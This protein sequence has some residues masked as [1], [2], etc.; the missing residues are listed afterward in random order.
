MRREGRVRLICASLP[1]KVMEKWKRRRREE[2][3]RERERTERGK[4]VW[5]CVFTHL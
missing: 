5:K 2:R 3:W 1:V 4:Q